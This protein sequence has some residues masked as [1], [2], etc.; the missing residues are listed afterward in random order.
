MKKPSLKKIN[1]RAAAAVAAS[2]ASAGI[3]VGGLFSYPG[4]LMGQDAVGPAVVAV[5]LT[6]DGAAGDDGG[7]AAQAPEEKRR[8]VR[9]RL[10]LWLLRL[11]P[12]LRASVGVP[13]WGLGWLLITVASALWT[14]LLSPVLGAALKFLCVAALLVAVLCVSLKAAFPQLRLRDVVNRRSVSTVLLG[15]ALVA[16][17]G[18]ALDIFYPQGESLRELVRWGGGFAVLLAAAVPVILK[19]PARPAEAEAPPVPGEDP[20]HQARRLALELADSVK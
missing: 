7:D 19:R 9:D 6:D 17:A 1:K 3:V 13:L 10:R 5:P 14:P 11:P 2:V 4:E 12:W 16:V 8:G 20:K 15:L 18:V